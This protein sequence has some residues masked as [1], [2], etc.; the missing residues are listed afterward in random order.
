MVVKILLYDNHNNL[1]GNNKKR[2]PRGVEW[3]DP[4][5]HSSILIVES[6]EKQKPLNQF[7]QIWSVLMGLY[8]LSLVGTY[9]RPIMAHYSLYYVDMDGNSKL[10]FKQRIVMTLAQDWA[11]N[12]VKESRS[13][14]VWKMGH[15]TSSIYDCAKERGLCPESTPEYWLQFFRNAYLY[16]GSHN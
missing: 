14:I 13:P 9:S 2:A 5:V 15:M 4:N 16:S 1:P 6:Q 3:F 10:H 11:E 8:Q 12:E 7:E